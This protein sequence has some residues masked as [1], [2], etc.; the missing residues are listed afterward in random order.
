MKT[1]TL[2]IKRLKKKVVILV[3][4]LCS[5]FSV[6]AQNISIQGTQFYV[7]SCNRIWLNGVNTPWHSWNDFGGSFD[8]NWWNTHF[9]TLK[10]QG[11]NCSRIWFSCNGNGAVLTNSTGVT[12]LS[13]AFFK[14]CDSL[15]AIAK[16]NGVYIVA[17]MMSF[18]HCKSPN[19]NFQNWRNII[20]NQA[21]SQ[22]YIDNYLLPFVN[23]YKSNPYL[24]AIDFCN[25]PEWI[26]ENAEDGQLPVSNLQRFFAMCAAAVHNNSNVLTTVGSACIKWNS[27]N[28]GCVGNYWKNAALQ[29]AFNNPKAYLDFY[30]VHYWGWMHQWFQSPFEKSPTNYGINDRPVI[31]EEL[32]GKDADLIDIPMTVTQSYETAFTKGYQGNL[33]WTS[34]GVDAHGDITTVGPAALSFKNNHT[35]LVYPVNT[36][37]PATIAASGSTT[38]CQGS[39]IVLTANPGTSYW[40]SNNATTQSITVTNPG[41]YYAAVTNG[42]GCSASLPKTVI[43][44]PLPPTPT[45]TASGAAAFCQGNS[46]I[47]TASS[48]NSY[49]WSNGAATQSITVTTAGNYSVSVTNVNGCSA[50]SAPVA[51]TVNPLPSVPIGAASQAFCNGAAISNLS[52]TGTAIKWY[53][54]S[55]GVSALATTTV[56]VN[57]THYF[58]SQ[59]VNTCESAARFDVTAA[60]N[61]A[62]NV[63]SAPSGTIAQTFCSSA[64][65]SNLSAA[66]AGIKWYAASS[67]GAALAA[68]MALVNG[69]H[70]FASQTVNT[71]ES[72]VRFDVTAAINVTPAPTGTATQTFCN[73]ASVAGLSAAGTALKWYA[74]SIGGTA[75]AATTALVNG[76]HYYATQTINACES[77]ARL[78]VKAAINVTSAPTGTATQTFCNSASLANLSAAGSG[79]KWYAGSTGGSALV[80]VTK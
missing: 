18:D 10:S 74:A 53:A 36:P 29:S 57:G 23:R 49:L 65:I 21:A 76:T 6:Q 67:G 20:T 62:I 54:A 24:F 16:R 27:D 34:N 50:S 1:N 43:V 41:N 52:V 37:S 44:N 72:A 75:L 60:I 4:V 7:N 69:T 8:R 35:S 79:I 61:T 31:I 12:G 70:Y 45:I 55:N 40:W 66:G 28:S 19:P 2:L 13:S 11:V 59:T 33:A 26:S 68:A 73:N 9:Q 14:D 17:T 42:I 22:T 78:N 71:C 30:C 3:L 5:G 47:L 56:L 15:F 38:F 25:E 51:V 58:A 39:S 46:V 77:A 63:P 48:S 80:F 64:A 32:G